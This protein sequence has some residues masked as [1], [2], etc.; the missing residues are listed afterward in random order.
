ML[1]SVW[2]HLHDILKKAKG[3]LGKKVAQVNTVIASSHNHIKITTKLQNH[4]WEQPEIW[5][6]E[7]PTTRELKKPHWDW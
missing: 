4:H 7:S 1:H 6:N 2:L 5:L 3:L